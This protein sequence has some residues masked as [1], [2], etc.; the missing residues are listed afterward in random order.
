MIWSRSAVE[1]VQMARDA[2]RRVQ[3]VVI[4]G[5]AVRALPRRHSVRSRQRKTRGGVIELSGGP[6]HRVMTG[7]AGGRD[8]GGNVCDRR[9]RVGVILHVA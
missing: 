5:V 7:L 9:D 3:G 2:G 8:A 6:Q 1:I 4:V